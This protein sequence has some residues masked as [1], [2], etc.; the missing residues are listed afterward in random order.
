MSAQEQHTTQFIDTLLARYQAHAQ[1]I[2]DQS[3]AKQGAKD[4][5]WR[6]ADQRMREYLARQEATQK[7]QLGA[8]LLGL[9]EHKGERV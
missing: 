2:A 3:V 9:G 1:H 6:T 7:A 8:R 4:E 5:G